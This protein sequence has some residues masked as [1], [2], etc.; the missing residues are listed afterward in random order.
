MHMHNVYIFMWVV[1][2]VRRGHILVK[3][4]PTQHQ[5]NMDRASVALA[6]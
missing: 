4:D 1:V 3:E 6:Q 5:K 2:V